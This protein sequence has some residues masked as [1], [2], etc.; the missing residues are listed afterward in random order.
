MPSNPTRVKICGI[1]R[2]E[3]ARYCAAAGADYLGFIQHRDSPRYVEPRTA[4]EI[5]EWSVGPEAVGVFVNR[6]AQDVIDTC[7]AGGFALAQLHGHETPETCAAVREAGVPVIK[8]VQVVSDAAAEQI[9]AIAEPYREAVDFLLL[10]THHTSLWGG[11]GESFN[12]R[13]ARQ[14]SRAFPTFLAGGISAENVVEAID[15]MRPFAVDLSSSLEESPGIKD[16][17][18]LADFFDAFR[19]ATE[20]A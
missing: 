1:T 8:S 16:F 14:V 20:A 15:T 5:M 2:L 13:L 4:K 19:A 6:E 18:K 12:W 7:A 9:L 3:D 17:D 10:D 11:T